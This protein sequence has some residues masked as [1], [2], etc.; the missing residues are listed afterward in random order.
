MCK[1]R[2]QFANRNW[3]L[4][5]YVT[6]Q[7]VIT[8]WAHFAGLAGSP[9]PSFSPFAVNIHQHSADLSLYS[10][11]S[12]KLLL[13]PF[14]VKWVQVYKKALKLFLNCLG[15]KLRNLQEYQVMCT[16]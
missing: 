1:D 14:A 5:Y 6:G 9:R 10:V 8:F 2:S 16:L 3:Q 4:R 7:H 13:M 12:L 15:Q 11:I